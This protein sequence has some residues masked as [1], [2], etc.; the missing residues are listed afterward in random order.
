MDH[1]LKLTTAAPGPPAKGSG[2][3][4]YL[5]PAQYIKQSRSQ[6]TSVITTLS[7]KLKSP[8]KPLV[9]I[10]YSSDP[11]SSDLVGLYK[12]FDE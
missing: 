7:F 2:H 1:T 4:K 12:S 9:L 8:A 11:T 3:R 10:E 6:L 5:V